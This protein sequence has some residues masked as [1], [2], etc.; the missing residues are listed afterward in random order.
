MKFFILFLLVINEI[1]AYNNVILGASGRTGYHL[2]QIFKKNNEKVKEVGFTNPNTEY[3]CD[4]MDKK[5]INDVI[6]NSENVFVTIGS[7]DITK[8]SR[9]NEKKGFMNIA[10]CC[11]ENNI[12]RLIVLTSICSRCSNRLDDIGCEMCKSKFISE[13]NIKSLYNSLANKDLSYTFVRVGRL[14]DDKFVGC[15]N[16]E[17][18][19]GGEKSGEISRQDVA[20]IMYY[21]SKSFH[22]KRTTFDVYELKKI[23]INNFYKNVK[24]CE[25]KNIPN[26]ICIYGSEA[27]FNTEKVYN[28]RESF[29][30]FIIGTFIH[31]YPYQ[32]GNEM[33]ASK[34]SKLFS[35]LKQD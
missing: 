31:K 4:M 24:A 15:S 27:L 22:T 3:K 35:K 21:A 8:K 10:E 33:R 18:N 9:E 7:P 30:R 17:I 19:Q 13:S 32:T 2:T 1:N 12:K 29:R 20:N 6:R 26:D 5:S 23:T 11:I 16:I 28:R 34:Y 25:D 14:T